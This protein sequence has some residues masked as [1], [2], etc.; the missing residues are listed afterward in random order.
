MDGEMK[1]NIASFVS[2]LSLNNELITSL[3]AMLPI[4]ELRFSIPY[5]TFA[6]DLEWQSALLWSLVGNLLPVPFILLLLDPAQKI[7]NRIGFMKKFFEWLFART[8]RRSKVVENY[9]VLGLALFVAIPLP[10]TGAWTGSVAAYIFGIRF[11]PSIIAITLGICIAGTIVT[12]ACQGVIGFW[13]L[14]NAFG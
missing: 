1:D 5:G 13:D 7:L 2:D 12:L 6:L 4:T 10:V 3:L 11:I 9:R 8:R 14:S